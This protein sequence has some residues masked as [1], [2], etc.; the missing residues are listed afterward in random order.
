MLRARLADPPGPSPPTCT[1]ARLSVNS[2]T[3]HS[4]PPLPTSWTSRPRRPSPSL[5]SRTCPSVGRPSPQHPPSSAPTPCRC[6]PRFIRRPTIIRS[7]KICSSR[8]HLALSRQN[9]S[10]PPLL[11]ARHC[12]GCRCST[13]RLCRCPKHYRSSRPAVG[14][15][16]APGRRAPAAQTP[17]KD[18]CHPHPCRRSDCHRTAFVQFRARADY[19]QPSRY[20]NQT[21]H[22]PDH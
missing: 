4:R 7:S 17:R 3:L 6:R 2:P 16:A 18:A 9:N 1:S 15:P 21:P 19:L 5:R 8:V 12:I 11:L 14:R 10:R 22:S 20:P 13:T